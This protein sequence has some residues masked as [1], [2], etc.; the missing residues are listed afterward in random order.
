MDF[1]IFFD[2]DGVMADFEAKWYQHFPEIDMCAMR[3][4]E[5]VLYNKIKDVD[6]YWT[7]IP[8]IPSIMPL[9]DY[10]YSKYDIQT[11]SAPLECDKE[12]CITGKNTFLDNHLG[13]Y[14]FK[15]NYYSH[16]NKQLMARP[17]AL[18]IDDKESNVEQF[19]ESGGL[20]ILHHTHN[21]ERTMD[22]LKR[23]YGL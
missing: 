1:T 18:L 7:D 4:G 8:F 22:I 3:L 12:R 16:E 15:R 17:N 14:E 23:G 9:W 21:T 2:M 19:R 10:C 5:R 6:N 20:A 11:L 13:D